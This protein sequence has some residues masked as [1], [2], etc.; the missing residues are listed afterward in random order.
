MSVSAQ[1]ARA[2][3]KQPG[4]AQVRDRRATRTR[5]ALHRALFSLLEDRPYETLTV[6]NICERADIGRSAFY[7]HFA[8]KDD[9]FR[10]GFDQL[11]E[12][13]SA[14]LANRQ[15]L[16]V[17]ADRRIIAQ[18]LFR[19]VADHARLYRA[20]ARDHAR[21][22]ADITIANILTPYLLNV[23]G[24]A[25]EVPK[26]VRDLRLAT[27]L[28]ALLAALHWWLDRGARLEVDTMVDEIMSTILAPPAD[29]R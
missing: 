11:E 17:A 23:L 19:H 18:T 6:L 25:D 3:R 21:R 1:K 13:L 5:S 29:Y 14:A 22:I 7:E 10:V 26:G 16:D 4:E 27:I 8:G 28:G 2:V 24:A 15:G 20:I 12:E 9:L